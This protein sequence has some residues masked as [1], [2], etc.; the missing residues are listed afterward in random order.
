MTLKDSK[1]ER[2]QRKG[3]A[4]RR[5]APGLALQH[6]T[7][8]QVRRGGGERACIYSANPQ[9]S[10][11]LIKPLPDKTQ[12]LSVG[13]GSGCGSQS[14]GNYR[15]PC[16]LASRP[17]PL[18]APTL[19]DRPLGKVSEGVLRAGRAQSREANSY[20]VPGGCSS[21][22]ASWRKDFFLGRSFPPSLPLHEWAEA[23]TWGAR[24]A[25]A[26]GG[27]EF[28]PIS[29]WWPGR[30]AQGPNRP[31]L[32]ARTACLPACPW[33]WQPVPRTVSGALKAWSTLSGCCPNSVAEPWGP[34]KSTMWV[35]SSLGS[36]E[37]E[38][39]AGI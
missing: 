5:T 14:V 11:P 31:R 15:S 30:A 24:A 10:T 16:C 9:A 13:C 12:T 27:L 33:A 8:E 23:R 28:T 3:K 35:L 17:G 26:R 37:T 29:W 1:R 19:R 39:Q 34:G 32:L 18:P 4:R 21:R 7:P 20:R 25:V 6:G 38:E 22:T 36:N 2:E